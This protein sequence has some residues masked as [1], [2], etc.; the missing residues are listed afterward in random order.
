MRRVSMMAT[1]CGLGLIALSLSHGSSS[2]GNKPKVIAGD[3]PVELSITADATPGTA[4]AG[5]N[6][7]YTVTVTNEGPGFASAVTVADSL[8]DETTFIS[9]AATGA[10]VC[11]GEGNNRTVTFHSIAPDT[12]ETVTLVA[13]LNCPLSDGEE[14]ANTASIRSAA[15]D[16]DDDEDDNETVFVTVSHPPPAITGVGVNP[17][18]IWPPNHKMIESVVDY[19]ATGICGPVTTSL[20]VTSN[21]PV[22]GTGDGDTSPDW[23]IVDAHHVRLRAERSGN[24]NGRTYTIGI[25]AT[26]VLNQSTSRTVAVRVPKNQK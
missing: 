3:E 24:G 19:Q 2:A 8:P 23:Q 18:A 4:P 13:A 16:S 9:C 25:T 26:D 21:E 7:T 11:G 6:I 20:S 15:P 14:V 10:G 12:S 17:A 1:F 22:D 5:S